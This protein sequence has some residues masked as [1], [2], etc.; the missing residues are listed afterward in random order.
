MQEALVLPRLMDRC[1]EWL[2][3]EGQADAPRS[4]C[5]RAA[6]DRSMTAAVLAAAVMLATSYKFFRNLDRQEQP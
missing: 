3:A 5:I 6:K 2:D 1:T 4:H